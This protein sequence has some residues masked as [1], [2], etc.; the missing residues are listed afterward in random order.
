MIQFLF[1][2]YSLKFV[3]YVPIVLTTFLDF[4]HPFRMLLLMSGECMLLS[5]C[6]VTTKIWSDG[7]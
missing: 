1:F 4:P 3:L 6:L 2:F 5:F 7:L